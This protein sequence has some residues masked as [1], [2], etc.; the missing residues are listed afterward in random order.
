MDPSPR[1]GR[2]PFPLGV[3]AAS[4]LGACDRPTH[5]PMRYSL[6]DATKEALA[7]APAVQEQILGSLELLFGTPQ[8]PA[9]VRTKDWIDSEFDPNHPEAAADGGGTG[10]IT[11]GERAAIREDNLVRFRSQLERVAKKDYRG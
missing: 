10:E 11:D 3:L 6:G 8:H 1:T 4:I 2:G 5:A 7:S 9:Y